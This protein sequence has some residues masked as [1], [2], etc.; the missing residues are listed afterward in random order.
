MEYLDELLELKAELEEII[1]KE[2]EILSN[3]DMLYAVKQLKIGA[4]ESQAAGLT[5]KYLELEKKAE[6]S[7][8]RKIKSLDPMIVYGVRAN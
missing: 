6:N 7:Y 5:K 3:E 1:D 8:K 4:L 2:V